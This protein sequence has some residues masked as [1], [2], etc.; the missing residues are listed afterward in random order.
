MTLMTMKNTR[1]KFFEYDSI[2]TLKALYWAD[3]NRNVRLQLLL[4]IS[5]IYTSNVPNF[6]SSVRTSSYVNPS[7]S[8]NFVRRSMH[9]P[10]QHRQ[11]SLFWHSFSTLLSVSFF[12]RELR[13]WKTKFKNI[14]QF[15][16]Y[17]IFHYINRER[18]SIGL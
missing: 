15:I 4:I 16:C 13:W 17:L 14:D 9:N 11:F 2:K 5:I 18:L 8:S 7:S 1:S 3:Y 10:E 6:G 12:I